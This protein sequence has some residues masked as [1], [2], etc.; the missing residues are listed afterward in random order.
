M[1]NIRPYLASVNIPSDCLKTKL[2]DVF[3]EVRASYLGV[4]DTSWGFDINMLIEINN[5]SPS[6]GRDIDWE[7][8]NLYLFE[9]CYNHFKEELK[10]PT[11]IKLSKTFKTISY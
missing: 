6:L 5:F 2:N 11:K 3:V 10:K 1:K 8:L 7:K 4:Q 9:L